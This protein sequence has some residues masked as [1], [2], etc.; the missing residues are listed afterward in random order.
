[1]KKVHGFINISNYNE[2]YKFNGQ[3]AMF[4]LCGEF[5]VYKHKKVA[6]REAGNFDK[7]IE[8]TVIEGWEK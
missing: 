7:T 3:P 8:I 1:M 6:I 4:S 2:P 5:T